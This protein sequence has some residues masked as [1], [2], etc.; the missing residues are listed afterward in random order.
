[1]N[2]CV[3]G[4][5]AWGTAFALHLVRLKHSVTLAPRRFEQAIELASRRENADY[6]PGFPLPHDLQISHE[7]KPAL[8]E[9]EAL[10]FACP[11]HALRDWCEAA[12]GALG[13]AAHLRYCLSLAKGLELDTGFRPSEVILQAMPGYITG[14]LT[15]PTRATEVA[16]GKPTAMTLATVQGAEAGRP[17]QEAFSSGSMR[18]Y[19]SDDLVGAELGGCLKNVYAIAVGCCEGLDLGDNARAALLTRSL[20]EMVRVGMAMGAKAETFYGLSG[21]GD[22]SATCYGPWSRNREF[23]FQLGRGDSVE[24]LLSHR[25]T[26]VEGYRSAAAFHG[27]SR[28]RGIEAPILEQVYQILYAGQSPAEGLRSLMGRGLKKE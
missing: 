15:G 19:R 28:E 5:G 26:V 10:V 8:M 9:A 11:S 16:E 21:F 12:V 20:T 3:L 2:V 1:M 7:L 25:R 18:I 4:A 6:L 14:C 17:L 24:Q 13:S 27:I 22:L 23:G